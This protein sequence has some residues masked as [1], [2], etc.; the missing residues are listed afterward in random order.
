[1]FL[2]NVFKELDIE[3]REELV[4]RGGDL[5][6][7]FLFSARSIKQG[8]DSIVDNSIDFSQE[9]KYES[10]LKG[11]EDILSY[12]DYNIFKVNEEYSIYLKE[13]ANIDLIDDGEGKYYFSG[14]KDFYKFLNIIGVTDFDLARIK[15]L[16]Y[17]EID[18]IANQVFNKIIEMIEHGNM[19]KNAKQTVAFMNIQ[20]LIEFNTS[21]VIFRENL[22]KACEDW[23]FRE[24]ALKNLYLSRKYQLDKIMQDRMKEQREKS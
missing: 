1:M 8:G 2:V 4:I 10:Q 5:T 11:I 24:M 7:P 18:K 3:K 14:A 13:E 19:D 20:S 15:E 12:V 16:V 22:G 17:T 23:S 9:Y 21:T 6:I